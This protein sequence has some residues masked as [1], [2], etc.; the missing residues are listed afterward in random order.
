[1]IPSYNGLT[2][3]KLLVFGQFSN[4]QPVFRHI[5]HKFKKNRM[6]NHKSSLINAN[7]VAV[8]PHTGNYAA[9]E[10]VYRL[11]MLHPRGNTQRRIEGICAD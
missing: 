5:L 1:M 3:T 9:I 10:I 11:D 8:H 2:E 7:F 6:K 4:L